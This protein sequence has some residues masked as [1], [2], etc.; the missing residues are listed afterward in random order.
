MKGSAIRIER[1]AERSLW[2]LTGTRS[3]ALAGAPRDWFS[4]SPGD[5]LDF[6]ARI[7]E[8]AWLLMNGGEEPPTTPPDGHCFPRDDSLLV[9]SG[10]AWRELMLEICSHDFSRA[11]GSDFVMTRAAGVAIWVRVPVAGEPVLIGCDPSYADYLTQVIE[12]VADEAAI[13]RRPR[14]G[15]PD[16]A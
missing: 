11:A 6:V 15:G 1:L 10:D 3:D 7:G 9:V 5:A 2:Q 16:E 13:A 12:S 14:R 8:D 4:Y